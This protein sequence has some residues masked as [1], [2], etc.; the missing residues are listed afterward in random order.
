MQF[1]EEAGGAGAEVDHRHTAGADALNQRARIGLHIAH[2]IIGAERA[3]PAIENLNGFGAA[4]RLQAGEIA[5][6]VN[7]LAH[8]PPPHGFVGVHQL[9]RFEERLRRPSF[10]HVTGK[11]KRRADKTDHRY[12]AR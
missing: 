7:Q 3:H 9:F 1:F 4:T 6:H 5:Q 2:I 8:Q 11:R 10:D 12:A